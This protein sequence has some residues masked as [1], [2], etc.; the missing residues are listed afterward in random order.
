MDIHKPK[1]VHGWRE[2]LKEYLIIVVGVLTAL[3]GEQG[4]EWLHWRHVAHVAEAHLASGVQTNLNNAARWLIIE[5]CQ[6]ERLGALT[7]GLQG[8]AGPWRANPQSFQTARPKETMIFVVRSPGLLWSHVGWEAALASG[9]LNHLP[10]EQIDTYAEIYRLVEVLRETQKQ[11]Q[12]AEARLAPLG[13]NRILNESERTQF[14]AQ[15]ADLQQF[16]HRM[17]NSSAQVL[18]DAHAIGIEP[19]AH[20]VA[21]IEAQE[22]ALR[23]RCAQAPQLPI[24]PN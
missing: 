1:P 19:D 12:G 7:A 10:A 17:Y 15:V 14:L 16:Y 21:K 6:G 5:P 2:F 11:A 9:A 24:P 22:R 8:S 4:V 18:R 3:A 23:G 20:S 13:Y